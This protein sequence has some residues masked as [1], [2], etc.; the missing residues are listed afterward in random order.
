MEAAQMAQETRRWALWCG[1][2][3]RLPWVV[4]WLSLLP[5]LALAQ[6]AP[7]ALEAALI[8]LAAQRPKEAAK[9]LAKEN[10]PEALCVR[11]LALLRLGEHAQADALLKTVPE[12]AACAQRALFDRVQAL[13][14]LRRHDEAAE[15]MAQLVA[16]LMGERRDADAAAWLVD[17]AEQLLARPTKDRDEIAIAL[18][19]LTLDLQ[20]GEE[21]RQSLG[22]RL[23]QLL[24]ER[25][26][27]ERAVAEALSTLFVRQGVVEPE[28]IAPLLDQRE[29]LYFLSTLGEAALTAPLRA[30]KVRL[31]QAGAPLWAAATPD[32]W[33]DDPLVALE[34]AEALAALQD[35]RAAPALGQLVA[36]LPQ[37]EAAQ[38]VRLASALWVQ[39]GEE[40]QAEKLWQAYAVRFPND[41]G[42]QGQRE[43]LLLAQARR[44]AQRSATDALAHYDALVAQLGL[45][46]ATGRRAALEASQLAL[47]GAVDEPTAKAR[48]EQLLKS[49]DS[50]LAEHGAMGLAWLAG[51]KRGLLEP[52]QQALRAIQPADL[53]QQLLAELVRPQ[54]HLSTARQR[55][56]QAMHVDV[57]VANLEELEM[58]LHRIDPVA[59][60]EAGGD[61]ER[62]PALDTALIAPDRRWTADLKAEAK[63]GQ[64]WAHRLPLPA[65]DSGLYR[66][67]AA[68]PTVEA[69]AVLLVSD[70]N[71]FAQR[72]QNTLHAVVF[73]GEQPLAGAQLHARLQGRSVEARSDAQGLARL[74]KLPAGRG[75]LLAQHKGSVALVPIFESDAPPTEA[76][77]LSL[78][79][80]RPVYLPG[81]TAEFWILARQRGQAM[82][83]HALQ[84]R[85]SSPHAPKIYPAQQTLRT[86]ALGV[87]SGRIPVPRLSQG[88]LVQ[89]FDGEKLL[90]SRTLAVRESGEAVNGH[91][92]RW[93]PDGSALLSL[94]DG[95]ALPRVGVA[96][97]VR[98][99]EDASKILH[100]LK[101]DAQGEVRIEGPALGLPW[102]FSLQA[103]GDTLDDDYERPLE[104][105]TPLQARYV[106][107]ADEAN[108][109]IEIL[110]RP[111]KIRVLIFKEEA[112]TKEAEAPEAPWLKPLDHTYKA[113]APVLFD[114][115]EESRAQQMHNL[116]AQLVV[117]GP[118]GD[119]Q[120]RA[121]V[122]RARLV[123]PALEAGHYRA[124]LIDESGLS[125]PAAQTLRWQKVP[126]ARGRLLGLRD[127]VSGQQLSLKSSAAPLWVLVSGERGVIAHGLATQK[128]PLQLDTQS[129]AGLIEIAAVDHQGRGQRYWIRADERLQI[130]THLRVE[131]GQIKL[132]GQ[133]RDGAGQPVPQAA[134][135]VTLFDQRLLSQGF[136]GQTGPLPQ[137]F[138]ENDTAPDQARPWGQT[139]L[140]HR[141]HGEAIDS[142]RLQEQAFAQDERRSRD[143][144]VKKLERI[145]SGDL[146]V[147]MGAVGGFG[148]R[149]HGAG[150]GG[151]HRGFGRADRKSNLVL[152]RPTQ[153]VSGLR[154]AGLYGVLRSDAEG[155]FELSAPHPREG[156]RWRLEAIVTDGHRVSAVER[157]VKPE[158]NVLLGRAQSAGLPGASVRLQVWV[159][160]ER[161]GEELQLVEGDQRWPAPPPGEPA[162]LSTQAVGRSGVVRLVRA[163]GA[164]IDELPWR[165][166]YAAGAPDPQGELLRLVA[167]P[168]GGYPAAHLAL[169]AVAQR[170]FQESHSREQCLSLL[171]VLPRAS[172]DLRPHLEAQL[173]RAFLEVAA[174]ERLEQPAAALCAHGMKQRGA[175]LGTLPEVSLPPADQ[176][177]LQRAYGLYAQ[178][179]LGQTVDEAVLA[180]MI[181]QAQGPTRGL[182]A[183]TLVQLGRS[184]EARPLA[185]QPDAQGVL[186]RRALG[187]GRDDEIKALWGTPPP[188]SGQIE[189]AAFL[190]AAGAL[191]PGAAKGSYTLAVEG[192]EPITLDLAAGFDVRVP[193]K[194]GVAPQIPQVE[195]MISV[196][197]GLVARE[198]P[199]GGLQRARVLPDGDLYLYNE[200]APVPC[201][202]AEGICTLKVGDALVGLDGSPWSGE[203]PLG[204]QWAQVRGRWT[205]RAVS[206]G[207]GVVSFEPFEDPSQPQLGPARYQILGAGEAA[208]ADDL[209]TIKPE[210]RLR[211]AKERVR[212]HEDPQAWLEGIDEQS[213]NASQLALLAQLRFDWSFLQKTDAALRVDRFEA[214]REHQPESDLSLRRLHEV[215]QAYREAGQP[216][217]AVDAWRAALGSVFFNQAAAYRRA[218]G[219]TGPLAAFRGLHT[220][221][222]RFPAVPAVGSA[223]FHLPQ[224]L[225]DLADEGIDP[226]LAQ[227]GITA[228]DL[229]VLAAQWDRAYLAQWPEGEEASQVGFHLVRTL[230]ALR[231]DEEVVRWAALIDQGFPNASIRDGV[232]FYQGLALARLGQATQALGV[233]E[234]V[235]E[236]GFVQADGTVGPS[237]SREDAW[238]AAGRVLEAK[239]DYEA[240]KKAYQ[241]A[242]QAGTAEHSALQRVHLEV[243]PQQE[244]R[245][246]VPVVEVSVANL[247]QIQVRA[248]QLDVRTLFGRDGH[249]EGAKAVQITGVSPSWSGTLEGNSSP[250]EKRVKLKLP[251]KGRG[252]W[253]VQLDGQG[254]ESQA[255]LVVRSRLRLV[256]SD[257]GGLLRVRALDERNR[258]AVNLAARVHD[259]TLRAQ[260]TDERGVLVVPNDAAVLVFDGDDV[261]FTTAKAKASH[262]RPPPPPLRRAPRPRPAKAPAS[263][264]GGLEQRFRQQQQMNR[265][266]FEESF[267]AD[268]QERGVK[269]N[270]F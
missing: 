55:P 44:V 165:V 20:I 6:K 189:R 168:G 127:V 154:R 225:S 136:S 204:F 182:L 152:Q 238:L 16:P 88:L 47:R 131:G 42:A 151:M 67:T 208:G 123:L 158:G 3:R 61:L 107:A 110:G 230:Y 255:T 125:A 193:T 184:S 54:I 196:R 124:L 134:L 138:L 180:R 36:H 229:R 112:Q 51:L 186:A 179:V 38:A 261:A 226:D 84:L 198:A 28:L 9:R 247:P 206:P 212:M 34:R 259:G 257:E 239:G 25:P 19:R 141:V 29:A 143:L 89:I 72:S 116:E 267:D 111:G 224:R 12:D 209:R 53:G 10:D 56:G 18:Y 258:P 173:Q 181:R 142:A 105:G 211:W 231:A 260:R 7:S 46:D 33:L 119:A 27:H 176:P 73:R 241:S 24:A 43:A 262:T 79:F 197:E 94:W 228:S 104:A 78:R 242:G 164:V 68:G 86:D 155:R 101:T 113:S 244:I 235:A 219:L 144:S 178:A 140:E 5:S 4:L 240:A 207:Q 57:Q 92:L 147:G 121:P 256:V 35:E 129:W 58:R 85:V 98:D 82:A 2:M 21:K 76:P 60:I 45:G 100:S 188:P 237:Q 192:A 236:G 70:L 195:G 31:I 253:L 48:L 166:G 115:L 52:A 62:L 248:Y 187:E 8:D 17:L 69:S 63:P 149:G 87:V 199:P 59:F 266:L 201:A 95:A 160:G 102:T 71:V 264:E 190:E 137:Q 249:L 268:D 205:L 254:A 66:I 200:R 40:A 169:E 243:H 13:G 103:Q 162:L 233:F 177:P 99:T 37:A 11:G 15:L 50:T 216:K 214:L 148:A 135:Q 157:S 93:Q 64:L 39:R 128:Q 150:G 234:L 194:D 145:S 146:S 81:D 210:D 185:D 221:A 65:L 91:A 122:G 159:E 139:A 191:G 252:G 250:Y 49:S 77:E 265:R 80:D 97:Q 96:V 109:A 171:G 114:D 220:V 269:A 213:L 227:L 23:A 218:E 41:G 126:Q 174:G 217:R 106:P 222:A 1:G 232:L 223:L 117:D 133:V 26:G 251:L 245:D 203:A 75:I 90:E 167:G 202:S 172:A 263:P 163:D 270:M 83:N 156:A 183:R 14:A 161:A 108:A 118:V 130:D 246:E 153:A 74:D 215:A 120:E 132:T 32:A 22:R 175:P 30:M 170:N